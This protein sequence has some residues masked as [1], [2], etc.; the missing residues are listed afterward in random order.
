MQ[1]HQLPAAQ[2]SG[3]V[4]LGN[5]ERWLGTREDACSTHQL[6][7]LE[8]KG[9]SFETLV[10]ERIRWMVH[11]GDEAVGKSALTQ[12]FQSKGAVFPKNYKMVRA[13]LR[14]PPQPP[15]AIR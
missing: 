1:R 10:T 15:A 8:R 14:P 4:E 11:A 7:Q 12:M 3:Q 5:A 2:H 6:T 13:L 9:S